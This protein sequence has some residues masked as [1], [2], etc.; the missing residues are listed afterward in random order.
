ME[1][2]TRRQYWFTLLTNYELRFV[3][4]LQPHLDSMLNIKM[5]QNEFRLWCKKHKNIECLS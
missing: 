3:C 2:S 5:S 1:E 4:A